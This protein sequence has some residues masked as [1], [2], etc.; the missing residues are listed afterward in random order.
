MFCCYPVVCA[1]HSLHSGL[2]FCALFWSV[3]PCSLPTLRHFPGWKPVQPYILA[4]GIGDRLTV[5]TTLSMVC[6]SG[7]NPSNW[8]RNFVGPKC[9]SKR[10]S[11]FAV[12]PHIQCP[13][14]ASLLSIF[15]VMI[16]RKSSLSF[17]SRPSPPSGDFKLEG[18]VMNNM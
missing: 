5:L 1:R 4:E 8:H 16:F 13:L 18:K 10:A 11:P 6:L 2:S 15:K 14:C 17:A 12:Q 9:I 3:F 7:S